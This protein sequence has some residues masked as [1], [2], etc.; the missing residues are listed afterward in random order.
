MQCSK[1]Q[2]ENP[3]DSNFCLECGKNLN[4]N[5]LNVKNSFQPGL[6]FAM[7]AV[8]TS[9][10]SQLHQPKNFPLMKN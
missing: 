6:N 4:K 2:F 7:V 8:I 10:Q 9:K 1:C 5:A 3:E